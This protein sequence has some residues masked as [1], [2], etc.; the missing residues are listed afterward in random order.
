[1]TQKI[2]VV[3]VLFNS[4]FVTVQGPVEHQTRRLLGAPIVLSAV[5]LP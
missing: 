1:M 5:T 2:D 3:T 4:D